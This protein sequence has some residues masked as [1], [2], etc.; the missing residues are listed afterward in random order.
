MIYN[1][2]CTN[3]K[4]ENFEYAIPYPDPADLCICGACGNEITKKEPQ[5]K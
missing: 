4:C 5:G 3:K 2:T 1:L